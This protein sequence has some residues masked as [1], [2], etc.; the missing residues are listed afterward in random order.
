MHTKY[1]NLRVCLLRLK[2][3]RSFLNDES[4]L[5]DAGANV[6]YTTMYFSDLLN[7]KKTICIEP[8]LD[9]ILIL[10]EQL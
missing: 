5:I 9:N 4:V 3:N 1:S 8:S 10:K 2:N 7:F 6:G